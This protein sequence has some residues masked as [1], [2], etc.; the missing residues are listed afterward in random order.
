MNQRSFGPRGRVV[1][2]PRGA[3]S[4][5]VS[6]LL[7]LSDCISPVTLL[8]G[9]TALLMAC[10][11]GEPARD[12]GA[13]AGGGGQTAGGGDS[14]GSGGDS[15]GGGGQASGAGGESSGGGGHA[16]G[17]GGESS[18]GGGQ[19]SGAGGESS[20]GGGA[21]PDPCPELGAGTVS[22]ELDINIPASAPHPHDQ[23]TPALASDGTNFLLVWSDDPSLTDNGRDVLAARVA[24]DGT[25]LDPE[26]LVVAA[27]AGDEGVPAVTFDGTHYV[28]VWADDTGFY[29]DP[30]AASDIRAA[31]I[32]P[33]GAVLDPGGFVVSSPEQPDSWPTAVSLGATTVVAWTAQDDGL[34]FTRLSPSGEVLD[35]GGVP[36]GSGPVEGRAALASDGAGALLAWEEDGALRAARVS[37][38][39]AVL[40]PGGVPIATGG[41][42]QPVAAF[43]GE[44]YWI[45]WK[46]D[47]VRA[48]RV[49]PGG[50]VLDPEGIPI[51]A[52]GSGELTNV[53]AAA[54]GEELLVVWATPHATDPGVT[55][56]L[57]ATRVSRAG[58]V[59]DPGGVVVASGSPMY[60]E[61]ALAAG[62]DGAFVAWMQ[63]GL[64]APW[65]I[66]GVALRGATPDASGP[67]P[68]AVTPADQSWP[69]VV[70][71]GQSY[72]VVWSDSRT[73]SRSIRAARVSASG[74]VLDPTGILVADTPVYDAEPLPVFDGRNTVVVWRAYDC[75][76]ATELYAARLS[77]AGVPLDAT[78]IRLPSIRTNLDFMVDMAVASDGHG[79]MIAVIDELGEIELIHLDQ[80]GGAELLPPSPPEIVGSS[81]SLGFDGTSYLVTLGVSDGIGEPGRPLHGARVSPSGEW[82]DTT[83][84]RIAREG[85]TAALR[86]P[87][88]ITRHGDGSL[89]V[90][91]EENDDGIGLYAAEIGPD[92]AVRQPGG[93]LF[94]PIDD[95]AVAEP[96]VASDGAR[97]VAVWQHTG[98]AESDVRGAELP[99]LGAEPE[100][101]TVSADPARELWPRVSACGP[102]NALVTYARRGS[103]GAFDVRGRLLGGG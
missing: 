11:G 12:P 62:D 23:F 25:V 95:A 34:R 44:Q 93:V 36:V 20:G 80:A 94:A 4:H 21:P 13:S 102:A 19:A 28:V 57:R 65:D 67:A 78:P 53:A 35:P 82:L 56:D 18:G 47:G 15:S 55:V 38:D 3:R 97:A 84:F 29:G 92:G 90:W 33:D 99:A 42:W 40:D 27:G 22:P 8:C 1:S 68:I 45:V 16:S 9:A 75:C 63:G 98:E 61:A 85:A 7:T 49:T 74:D 51:H 73:V 77:P 81:V 30:Y 10:S 83:A 70:F 14:S 64:E 71:D 48:A 32:S 5:A 41:G 60:T 88:A 72:V 86:K 24:P 101:L 52:G 89:V 91:E 43:D 46:G 66:F 87:A 76:G 6:S 50:A 37:A 96:A 58:A 100:V 17:A 79:V 54:D 31:R 69:A 2:P 39:G 103:T 59:L 26:P